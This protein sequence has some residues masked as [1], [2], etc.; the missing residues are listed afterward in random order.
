MVQFSL[1]YVSLPRF[2]LYLTVSAQGDTWGVVKLEE[3]SLGNEGKGKR[4]EGEWFMTADNGSGSALGSPFPSRGIT[5]HI[6][7]LQS[8]ADRRFP[9]SAHGGHLVEKFHNSCCCETNVNYDLH[10]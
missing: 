4:N 2:Y 1:I 10:I 7:K 6:L 3:G 5:F 8:H 9:A